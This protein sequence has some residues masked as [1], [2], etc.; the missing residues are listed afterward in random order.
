M[1]VLKRIQKELND[2]NQDP[3][4]NITAKLVNDINFFLWNATILG[5]E[6]TPYEGGVYYLNIHFPNDYPFKPPKC[7]FETRIYHPNINSMGAIGLDI[8]KD[9]WS[10][11][12]TISHVLLEIQSFLSDFNPFDALVPE[13]G[14]MYKSDKYK[15]YKT[16]REWA[17]KYANAPKTKNEFE[18]Y[19]LLGKDRIDYELKH[20]KYKDENFKLIEVDTPYKYKAN[21]KLKNNS[22]YKDK[23]LEIIFDF[24]YYY[25]KKPVTVSFL[26]SDEYLNRKNN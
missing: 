16:A 22:L 25:P 15:F 17:I 6:D 13:I 7:T 23:N 9:Q 26:K 8:L 24:P 10:P 4:L 19:H 18:F 11:A 2:F 3:P 14:I 5:P 1:S 20:I 12:Y 21:L